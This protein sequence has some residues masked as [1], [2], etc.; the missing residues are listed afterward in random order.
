[1]NSKLMT[2][3]AVF[4]TI[5]AFTA[6]ASAGI[7]PGTPGYSAYGGNLTILYTY[8][9]W[10]GECF[11]TYPGICDDDNNSSTA[12]QN[13][14]INVTVANTTYTCNIVPVDGYLNGSYWSYPSAELTAYANSNYSDFDIIFFD[15]VNIYQDR[16]GE[17][18][19]FATGAANAGAAGKLLAAVRTG[20]NNNTCYMPLGFAIRD[21]ANL[22]AVLADGTTPNPYYNVNFTT[23]FFKIHDSPDPGA[24][25]MMGVADDTH[26]DALLELLVAQNKG[27]PLPTFSLN[28]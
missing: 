13:H 19:Y 16:P 23:K 2:A 25:G 8:A 24:P 4:I 28:P 14:T 21:T 17:N 15:M 11:I 6:T 18:A 7:D 5:F 3:L 1:M 10:D 22:S 20:P 9:S 27:L 12:P 26:S